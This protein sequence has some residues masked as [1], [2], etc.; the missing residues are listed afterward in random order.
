MIFSSDTLIGCR[1][2]KAEAGRTGD[3]ARTHH[4]FVVGR[5]AGRLPRTLVGKR[6]VAFVAEDKASM[7]WAASIHFGTGTASR[8]E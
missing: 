5:F 6:M 4:S 8:D 7:P 1:V 2:H 3:I